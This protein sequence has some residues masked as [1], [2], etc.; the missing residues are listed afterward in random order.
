MVNVEY[1][2]QCSRLV[3]VMLMVKVTPDCKPESNPA[4]EFAEEFAKRGV[5]GSAKVD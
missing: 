5:H 1:E 2:G 4:E 3:S